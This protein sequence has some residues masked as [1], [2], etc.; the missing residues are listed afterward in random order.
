M[1]TN[2][3]PDDGFSIDDAYGT[4]ISADP[5]GVNGTGC[6]YGLETE[7]GVMRIPVKRPVRLSGLT[8]HA[9][10]QLGQCFSKASRRA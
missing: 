1:R 4:V 10:W 5:D 2:P 7:T 6:M 9:G 3:K 8:L